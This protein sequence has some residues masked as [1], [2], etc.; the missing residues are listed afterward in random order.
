MEI[1]RFKITG[2]SPILQNNPAKMQASKGTELGGKKTYDPVIEAEAAV[3]RNDRKEI[4]VP[5]IAFRAAMFKA[6]T[7]RKINKLSA[8]TAVAA[9]VFPVEQECIL[10]DGKG[11]PIK[12][13]K[14]HSCRCVVN[15]AG[16]IRTRPMIEHWSTVLALEVDT[17]FLGKG[18]EQV[19][20]Q[21]LNLAGKIAGVMD[22]RPEK[23]GTFGRFTAKL[24]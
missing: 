24:I 21:L 11:K 7:G 10:L 9:S 13:Y 12:D 17:N 8:K 22:W 23:L 15:K 19:L 4:V 16:I 14:I 20:E 2:V 5:S 3:Y 1:V 6:C 18:C